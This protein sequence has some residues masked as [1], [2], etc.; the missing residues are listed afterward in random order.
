MTHIILTL[1]R[2]AQDAM[3][4]YH[5]N[6]RITYGEFG[7][8]ILINIITLTIITLVMMWLS[9]QLGESNG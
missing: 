6:S 8:T 3:P 2:A 4:A 1:A 7:I 9:L 5:L